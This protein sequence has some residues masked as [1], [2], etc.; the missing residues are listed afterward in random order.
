L[1]SFPPTAPTSWRGTVVCIDDCPNCPL[2]Q[3]G[4]AGFVAGADDEKERVKGGC[5]RWNDLICKDCPCLG[6]KHADVFPNWPIR[7]VDTTTNTDSPPKPILA[8][9][10]EARKDLEDGEIVDVNRLR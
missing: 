2:F 3:N 6:S 10:R 7:T 8:K 4:C 5:N 9:I 1:S